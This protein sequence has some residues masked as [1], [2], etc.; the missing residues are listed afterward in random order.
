MGEGDRRKK[1]DP[2]RAACDHGVL[3]GEVIVDP[4][5]LDYTLSAPDTFSTRVGPVGN[6]RAA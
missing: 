4:R 5:D 3:E 6:G 2:G 1:E